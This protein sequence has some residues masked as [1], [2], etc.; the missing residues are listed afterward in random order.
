MPKHTQTLTIARIRPI[1]FLWIALVVAPVALTGCQTTGGL[2]TPTIT[3]NHQPDDIPVP[4]FFEFDDQASWAYLTFQNA[5][6]PMRSLEAVYWG[7]RP[8][9]ELA[10]WYRD[11]LRVDR[12]SLGGFKDAGHRL[13]LAGRAECSGG[14]RPQERGI[15]CRRGCHRFGCRAVPGLAGEVGRHRGK[16]V[17]RRPQLFGQPR[18]GRRG[19]QHRR[20]TRSNEHPQ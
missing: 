9:N 15:G 2:W 10:S 4:Q 7:D 3:Q 12:G 17:C 20:R 8:I 1:A 11:H 5:R 19:L 16:G 6:M 13:G 14:C 18:P